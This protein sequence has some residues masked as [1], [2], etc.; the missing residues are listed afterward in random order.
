MEGECERDFRRRRK[1]SFLELGLLLVLGA[2][3]YDFK[4]LYFFRH[5]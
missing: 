5:L 1:R 2:I 3:S 4:S